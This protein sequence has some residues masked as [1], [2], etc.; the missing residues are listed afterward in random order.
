MDDIDRTFERLK[1]EPFEMVIKRLI[2]SGRA[3]KLVS[4]CTFESIICL[5][6]IDCLTGTG[7][8]YYEITGQMEVSVGGRILLRR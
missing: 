8:N 1:R 5:E 2:E 7:W 3:V 4:P 6:S